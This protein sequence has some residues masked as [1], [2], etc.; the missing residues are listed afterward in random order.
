[1]A[2]ATGVASGYASGRPRARVEKGDLQYLKNIKFTWSEMSTFL[3]VS[4]KTLQRRAKEWNIENYS[5]TTDQELDAMVREVLLDFPTAGE[6]MLNGHLRSRGFHVQRA[7]LRNSIH[8]IRGFN[9]LNQPIQRRSYSV[10]GPNY[11][12]HVDG[13]H[14]LVRFKLVIHAAIDGFSRLITFINCANN[15]RAETVL[16]QFVNATS[17]YGIP[18]RIRTDQGGENADIWQYITQIRGEGRSSYITGSSVHNSRIERLWRDV[19]TCVVSTFAE[20]FAT[21]EDTGVLDIENDTDLFCLH[22]VFIP[23][24]NRALQYFKEAWNSHALSTENNWSPTQLFVAFSRDNPLFEDSVDAQTYG[25]DFDEDDEQFVDDNQA[26]IIPPISSPLT[27]LTLLRLQLSINP[28][29]YSD[30]YG[31]DLYLQTVNLVNTFM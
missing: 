13:N 6:V 23:R 28:L 1:M 15:N 24:I 31:A 29:Q 12:W 3:G 8:R 18:S 16:E 4:T 19:R 25:V 30:C 22:F 9:T 7:R 14:K 20:I 17:E 11:L 21:L 2:A 27:S 5:S 26:V 10:P